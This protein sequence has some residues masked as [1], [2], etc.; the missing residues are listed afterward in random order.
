MIALLPSFFFFAYYK[1]IDVIRYTLPFL[2]ALTMRVIIPVLQVHRVPY[3][4]LWKFHRALI[5]RF[6]HDHLWV[7]R[8][9]CFPQTFTAPVILPVLQVIIIIIIIIL[10]YRLTERNQTSKYE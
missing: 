10:Y 2:S 5:L 9:L 3:R 6:L 7:I 8:Y 1:I 4:D